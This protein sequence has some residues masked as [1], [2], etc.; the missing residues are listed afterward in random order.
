MTGM[1]QAGLDAQSARLQA[2]LQASACPSIT[3]NM[4]PTLQCDPWEA[5]VVEVCSHTPHPVSGLMS[6]RGGPVS[7]GRRVNTALGTFAGPLS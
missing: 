6:P 3:Y 4:S 7:G 5:P 2:S 1:G